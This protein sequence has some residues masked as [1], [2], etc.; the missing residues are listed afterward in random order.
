MLIHIFAIF[1]TEFYSLSA[2]RC[3][4]SCCKTD[5]K[6]RAEFGIGGKRS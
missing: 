4:N 1:Y 5:E 3:R 2:V 6:E